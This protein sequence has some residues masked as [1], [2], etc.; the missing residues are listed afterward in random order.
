M[1]IYTIKIIKPKIMT[2]NY[3]KKYILFVFGCI[4]ICKK[5]TFYV[6]HKGEKRGNSLI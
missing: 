5:Q 1:Q 3:V 6:C 2:K 4:L